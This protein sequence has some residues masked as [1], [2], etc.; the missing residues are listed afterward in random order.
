MDGVYEIIKQA[1]RIPLDELVVRSS[2]N[3]AKVTETVKSLAERGL[4]KLHGPPLPQAP[5]DAATAGSTT[6]EISKLAV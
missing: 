6:I 1:G 3:A 5:E 2:E 4:V